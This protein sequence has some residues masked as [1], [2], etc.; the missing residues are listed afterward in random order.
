MSMPEMPDEIPEVIKQK[1]ERHLAMYRSIWNWYIGPS[2]E[3]RY[4]P[5]TMIDHIR[6]I[7]PNCLF[8]RVKT[9]DELAAVPDINKTRGLIEAGWEDIR[10]KEGHTTS[11]VRN[12]VTT[13]NA[14]WKYNGR[15]I[16][17]K[18][19]YSGIEEPRQSGYR[20]ARR[21]KLG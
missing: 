11:Y 18:D 2:G 9:P 3:W 20:R 15:E 19:T 10:K 17:K 4:K 12:R 7:D 14:F 13:M 8:A 21:W 5:S 1:I 16:A 6:E